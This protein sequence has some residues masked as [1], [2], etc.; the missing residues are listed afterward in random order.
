MAL[1]AS[2]CG[3]MQAY[4]DAPELLA[5]FPKLPV[6]A[7]SQSCLALPRAVPSCIAL[8]LAPCGAAH[9]LALRHVLTRPFGA[10]P[11]SFL[12]QSDCLPDPPADLFRPVSGAQAKTYIGAKKGAAF[13]E[14]RRSQVI[15]GPTKGPAPKIDP[16]KRH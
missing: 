5:R 3:L 15:D 8:C 11:G 4:A 7:S 9:S 6:R 12:D 1:I 13:V 2:V 10:R 14:E 16:L